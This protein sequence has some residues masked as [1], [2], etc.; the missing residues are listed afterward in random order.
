V[1]FAVLCRLDEVA[2]ALQPLT[3]ELWQRVAADAATHS[4]LPTKLGLTWRIGYGKQQSRTVQLPGSIGRQ[5]RLL[6]LHEPSQGIA[7]VGD[8]VCSFGSGGGAAGAGDGRAGLMQ[9]WSKL[10]TDHRS[11]QQQQQQ[12]A[13]L[14]WQTGDREQQEPLQQQ[15]QG[16]V[17]CKMLLQAYLEIVKSA[18]AVKQVNSAS[19]SAGSGRSKG[20]Q[21]QQQAGSSEAGRAAGGC[22]ITK[23]VL[24]A[25]Y[26]NVNSSSQQCWGDDCKQPGCIAREEAPSLV[27]VLQSC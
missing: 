3:A 22:N 1:L 23:L 16:D 25:L 17:V 11:K 8:A 27:Q 15:Q 18:A 7:G 21:K 24:A 9:C 19:S 13:G 10:G 6:L 26:A 20:A 4:R 5:M 14:A 12:Q 2:A